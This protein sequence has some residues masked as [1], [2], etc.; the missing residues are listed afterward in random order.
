[1]SLE[2]A[3]NAHTPA[4]RLITEVGADRQLDDGKYATCTRPS[5]L[6]KEL[7]PIAGRF[8]PHVLLIGLCLSLYLPGLTTIPPIDRD[9]AHFAQATTEMLERGDFVDVR[10]H[11]TP[12]HKKPIG[13]FWLQLVAIKATGSGRGAEIWPFRLP[14]AL[15]GLLAVL[16]TFW[17]WRRVF[18]RDA[19]LL[20]AALLACTFMT[21]AEA[22]MAIPDASLLAAVV[23]VQ[24]VLAN[25]YVDGGAVGK[26][27]VL[28]ALVFW[29]ALAVGTLVKG[30]VVPA[31]AAMTVMALGIWDGRWRWIKG[32]R[33]L[34]GVPLFFAILAPWLVAVAWATRGQFFV[35]LFYQDYL[36]RFVSG[37]ETHGAPP[38]YYIL[39]S[40]VSFWPLS[41]FIPLALAHAWRD[42]DDPA[43]RFCLAWILPHWA[44]MEL[45]PTKLPQYVF[46]VLPALALI[47]GEAIVTAGSGRRTVPG[48]FRGWLFFCAAVALALGACLAAMP[49][50]LDQRFDRR[51]V[52]AG[53]LVLIASAAVI[54]LALRKH[55]RTAAWLSVAACSL[56]LPLYL[57]QVVPSLD[58]LWIPSRTKQV[59]ESA[60]PGSLTPQIAT[61]GY[62]EPSL[63]LLFGTQTAIL[64]PHDCARF[65]CGKGPRFALVAEEH[66]KEFEK[67]VL[68]FG[69]RAV[70][71]QRIQGLN[72]TKGRWVTLHIYRRMPARSEIQLLHS[73]RTGAVDRLS[74]RKHATPK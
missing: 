61:A 23:A 15:G 21:V 9:E 71:V 60:S 8:W 72:Y 17:L 3:R 53:I 26:K 16:L 49:W 63:V 59:I 11:G 32:L 18:G 65:L 7:A 31:L 27:G 34:I 74:G 48:W 50:I 14:S 69:A 41:V 36:P 29:I 4:G 57:S 47:A 42:R 19:A 22:H 73:R 2:G 12:W 62:D 30:P 5:I 44:F 55:L 45:V 51:A 28:F 25:C 68:S 70:R 24:G 66:C 54:Q 20:A 52:A 43:I 1:M 58:A 6:R 64:S 38:G 10:Y 37:Y 39:I 67:S 35:D 13:I 56:V 46:P 33:P 40:I